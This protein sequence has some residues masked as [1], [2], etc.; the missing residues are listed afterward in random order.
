MTPQLDLLNHIKAETPHIWDDEPFRCA[1]LPHGTGIPQDRKAAPA[2][3]PLGKRMTGPTPGTTASTEAA[4]RVTNICKT[5]WDFVQSDPEYRD[6]TT[7]IFLTN[8]AAAT[9]R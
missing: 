9:P 8:Q 7:L 4:H 6:H 1:R 2:L 3:P 5:L